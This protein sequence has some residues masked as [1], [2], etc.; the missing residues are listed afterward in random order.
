MGARLARDEGD[1]V[2]QKSSR[3]CREQALLPQLNP[4]ATTAQLPALRSVAE[5][6]SQFPQQHFGLEHLADHVVGLFPGEA[7]TF[8]QRIRDVFI[9][10]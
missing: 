9:R 4:L 5:L 3:L 2:S 6:R 10:A 7:H 1:A 8:E